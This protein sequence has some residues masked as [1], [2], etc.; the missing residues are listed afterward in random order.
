MNLRAFIYRPVTVRQSAPE[1]PHWASVLFV[2]SSVAEEV[3]R[4]A[5]L[6]V[7]LAAQDRFRERPQADEALASRIETA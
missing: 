2:G 7:S 1:V 5:P 6:A 3:E 4:S